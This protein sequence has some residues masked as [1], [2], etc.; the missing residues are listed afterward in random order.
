[1]FAGAGDVEAARQ[2]ERKYPFLTGQIEKAT[3]AEISLLHFVEEQLFYKVFSSL[4]KRR[5]REGEYLFRANDHAHAMYIIT[6]GELLVLGEPQRNG[7][8]TILNILR[9]G[10]VVGEFSILFTIPRSADVLA[11]KECSLL[12]I[13]RPT[14]MK[15]LDQHPEAAE[16]LKREAEIRR[17]VSAISLSPLLSQLP[18]HIRR[19]MAEQAQE[20]SFG[21][22]KMIVKHGTPITNVQLITDGVARAIYTP[23]SKRKATELFDLYAGDMV[24][25]A[26]IIGESRHPLSIHG[27]SQLRILQWPL[28]TMQDIFTA[29]SHLFLQLKNLF[30]MQMSISLRGLR[31][32]PNTL[33]AEITG[34]SES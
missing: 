30:D 17:R 7:T 16:L 32:D 31:L 34:F 22:D 6:E 23:P 27:V 24:G 21:S 11:N 5:L 10:D 29:F 19:R 8:R 2:L 13:T 26:A 15:I 9:Q 4:R 3:P 20:Y 18:L 1:L 12:E 25:G 33:S 28:A 14:L